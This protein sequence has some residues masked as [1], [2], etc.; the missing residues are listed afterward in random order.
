MN[1]LIPANETQNIEITFV[2]SEKKTYIAEAVLKIKQFD[3]EPIFIKLM[4]TGKDKKGLSTTK[5]VK[6][7]KLNPLKVSQSNIVNDDQKV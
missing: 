3:F 2:P 1:G 4:G 7:S 6:S 5:R